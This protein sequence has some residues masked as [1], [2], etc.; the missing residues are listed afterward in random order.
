[1]PGRSERGLF[2]TVMALLFGLL[3][4]SN[5]TKAFQHLHSPELGMVLF[6][7]RL[8]GFASN[9][10]FGSLLGVVLVAYA[11][12][13]WTLGRWVLPL[14]MAY[15][16]WVPLNLVL[17]WYRQ[18]GPDIPPVGSLVGYLAVAFTGSIGTALYLAYHR[19]RLR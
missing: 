1:M 18:T 7:I 16:F 10:I 12:G 2:L 6:G 13:L 15:A 4:L 14:S 9:L 3:A 17:F 11:Y 19:D 8:T 5:F